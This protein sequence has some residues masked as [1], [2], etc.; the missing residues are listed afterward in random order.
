MAQQRLYKANRTLRFHCSETEV[1]DMADT[2]DSVPLF[3]GAVNIPFSSLFQCKQPINPHM[4]RIVDRHQTF[5]ESENWPGERIE[6]DPTLMADAGFYYLGDS[7]RVKC[8]YCNGGLKN[9]ERYDDPWMEHAKWFPLCEYLLKNKGVDF[10]KAVVKDFPGLNRPALSNPP[11]D[12]T[13]QG[14]QKLVKN[15][16]PAKRELLFP[17]LID[18]RGGVDVKEEV[19]REMLLGKNVEMAKLLGFKDQKIARVLTKQF[20][21]NQENFATFYEFMEKLMEEPDVVFKSKLTMN[22]AKELLDEVKCNKCREEESCVMYL[23]CA[24]I[25]ECFSCSRKS[26]LCTL[27]GDIIEEKIRTYR[28]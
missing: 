23:P 15:K 21:E 17:P 1:S 26:H 20:R 11:P 8:W 16:T 12:K 7:D 19:E 6:A 10:V 27:C 14:L 18:P 28:V 13:L 22:R 4:R 2:C 3:G 5:M 25:S 9:W 24:H